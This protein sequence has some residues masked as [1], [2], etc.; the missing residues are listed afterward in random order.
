MARVVCDIEHVDL[1]ND[2]GRE[3]PGVRATCSECGHCTESF[4]QSLSSVRR[5][6]VLMREQCPS[7]EE[8]FYVDVDED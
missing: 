6:L 1:T 7:A 2:N 8:N 5:C 3:V 4:G